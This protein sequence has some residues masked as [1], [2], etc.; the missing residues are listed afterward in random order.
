MRGKVFIIYDD[1]IMGNLL[2]AQ[3]CEEGFE[4]EYFNNSNELQDKIQQAEPDKS[5]KTVIVADMITPDTDGYEIHRL[6]RQNSDTANIPFVFL[7]SEPEQS[8]QPDNFRTGA[9]NYIS[10]PFKIEDLL[11]HIETA[12]ERAE[13]ASSFESLT[14]F[15]GDLAQMSLSDV[16][17]IAEL[18]HKTGELSLH[19]PEGENIGSAFFTGGRLT[20][21]Q[22]DTLEGEE[23]FYDLMSEEKGYF[24]FHNREIDIPEQISAADNMTVL[25]NAKFLLDESRSFYDTFTEQDV[26]LDIISEKIPPEIEDKAGKDHLRKILEMIDAGQTVREMITS[27]EMSRPGAGYALNLLLNADIIAVAENSVQNAEDEED[28]HEHEGHDPE[29][30]DFFSNPRSSV[31]DAETFPMIEES[32]LKALNTF[33]SRSVNGVLEIRDREEKAAICFHK[34]HIVH[35]YYGSVTGKKALYRIFSGKGGMLVFHPRSVT[36]ENTVSDSLKVLLDEGNREVKTLQRLKQSSFEKLLHVNHEMLEKFSDIQ[37]RPSLKYTLSLAKQHNKVRDIIDA[38]RMTDLQTYKHLLYLFQRGILIFEPEKKPP[39]QLITD[40]AADLPADI[41]S[42][43]NIMVTPIS[44]TIG[45]KV[46]QDGTDSIPSDFYP[47]LKNSDSFPKISLPGEDE[48]QQLFGT[49]IPEKDIFAIFTSEKL[50]N[51]SAHAMNVREKNYDEYLKQ[52]QEG[53]KT[54]FSLKLPTANR[55][56]WE[57][58]CWSWKPPTE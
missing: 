36:D 52:R 43:R 11:N 22:T 6:L 12:M 17:E 37:T 16:L 42:G 47:L 8:D 33:E 23:A 24:E 30:E 13:K 39:I 10:K 21:A 1:P 15:T 29:S 26:S 58:A 4:A 50:S 27:G 55:S 5:H 7:S 57:R 48:L 34:G 20:A 25:R 44:V 53:E 2:E 14:E 18:N 3:L 19:G 46:Y 45:K 28:K 9:D 40:S 31:S 32:L 54:A 38:S 41:I 35:A 51:I 56:P 49:I